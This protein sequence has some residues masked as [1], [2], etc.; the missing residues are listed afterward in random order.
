MLWVDK[1]GWD[2]GGG[3]QLLEGE[4]ICIHVAD[5]LHC[6]AETNSIERQLYASKNQ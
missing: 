5:S 3:G 1:E 2:G 6:T 4:D